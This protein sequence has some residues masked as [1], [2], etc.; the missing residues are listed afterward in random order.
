MRR[1]GDRNQQEGGTSSPHTTNEAKTKSKK[2]KKK[3]KQ[4][5]KGE[6]NKETKK[7][8][9]VLILKVADSA[10]YK[11]ARTQ[12]DHG[13]VQACG[14]AG[15]LERNGRVGC[16]SKLHL[17]LQC[18]RTRLYFSYIRHA[19]DTLYTRVL[20][21]VLG[22]PNCA[23]SAILQLLVLAVLRNLLMDLTLLIERI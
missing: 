15:V 9:N 10:R 17:F 7:K 21:L 1:G 13:T 22:L 8:E 18:I 16:A 23:T 14:R 19:L 20:E 2:V 3:E 12:K 5:T 6:K 4:K 11:R